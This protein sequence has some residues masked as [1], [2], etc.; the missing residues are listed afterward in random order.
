MG[1]IGIWSKR[2]TQGGKL[3]DHFGVWCDFDDVW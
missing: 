1:D 3:A 2:S